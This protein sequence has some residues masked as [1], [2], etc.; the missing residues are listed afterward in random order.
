MVWQNEKALL[1]LP[2]VA[3][4]AG[5]VVWGFYKKRQALKK[6]AQKQLLLKINATVST[7]KQMLKAVMLMMALTLVVLAV[8]EPKWNPKPKK[9]K[10]M[11]R[12]VVV[13]LDVSRSM[14]AEDVSPSRLE[15]AKLA[16][17]DLAQ[18]LQGDRIALV[19]FAGR[20]EILCPLTTD[21]NFVRMA[22][23]N[24]STQTS[25][26]GGTVIG[27][28]IR[29]VTKEMFKKDTEGYRDIVLITDGEDHA[30]YPV[31]AA[32]ICG[33]MGV[34]II[35]IAMGDQVTGAKIPIEKNDGIVEYVKYKGE[36]VYSKADQEM[37]KR[38]AYASSDGRFLAVG[39]QTALD[40]G[41]IYKELIVSAKQRQI[42]EAETN[43][44]EHKFQLF[45]A[46]AIILIAGEM[47]MGEGKK[48]QKI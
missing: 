46:A 5:V 22:I 19:V 3:I 44:Y 23:D 16:I 4:L 34:R 25:G 10:I 7:K 27:D 20:A 39:P 26:P 17:L 6:F 43:E 48:R 30:S 40:L 31:Q 2:F 24:I 38:V 14:L 36:Y 8:C 11:G 1:L 37:L 29:L 45:L 13:L 28:A 21:W 47:M 41:E 15:K 35:A 18:V 32:E 33:K 42:K 9:I 12:D